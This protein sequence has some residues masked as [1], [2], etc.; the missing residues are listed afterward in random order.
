MA[1]III[2]MNFWAMLVGRSETVSLNSCTLQGFPSDLDVLS[3]GSLRGVE[4][5]GLS[6]FSSL[7]INM[8]LLLFFNEEMPKQAAKKKKKL[9]CKWLHHVINYFFL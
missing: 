1:I 7:L 4:T 6:Q 2:I 8:L 9:Y 5:L 3:D